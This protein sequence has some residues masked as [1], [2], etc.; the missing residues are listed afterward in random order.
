MDTH[1]IS[2]LLNDPGMISGTDLEELHALSV[3]YPYASSLHI[4]LAK[5]LHRNNDVRFHNQLK[6]TA[7]HSGD[8]RVLYQLIMQPELHARIKATEAIGTAEEGLSEET[9]A[10]ASPTTGQEN[11]T[12]SPRI[13]ELEEQILQ[14]AIHASISIEA[15]E[16]TDAN[17]GLGVPQEEEA[18]LPEETMEAKTLPEI[19]NETTIVAKTDAAGSAP[20]SMEP[21]RPKSFMQWLRANVNEDEN[22]VRK[23]TNA[24]EEEALEDRKETEAEEPAESTP[25]PIQLIEKFIREEPRIV[26]KKAAFFNPVNMTRLGLVDDESFV[27]ETLAKVY[28]KQGRYSK[29]IRVYEAL[30]LKYP[31]KS[32]YFANLIEQVRK[33]INT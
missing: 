22:T 17:S 5:G 16:S 25:E 11:T 1:H 27:T 28:I 24:P 10:E 7:L 29:A 8:R 19:Q 23:T 4:L 18:M 30:G 13:A 2:T 21:H 14:E 3:Q 26:P 33:S 12:V 6:K 31:E 32:I 20:G 15:G 9:L